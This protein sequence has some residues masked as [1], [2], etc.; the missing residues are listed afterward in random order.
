MINES[1]NTLSMTGLHSFEDPTVNRKTFRRYKP[2]WP[3]HLFYT[4][5]LRSSYGL[6]RKDIKEDAVYRPLVLYI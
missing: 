6:S 2:L 3:Y 5:G 4:Y 1:Q